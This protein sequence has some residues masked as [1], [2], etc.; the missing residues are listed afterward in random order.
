MHADLLTEF[1]WIV[2]SRA[3][4]VQVEIRY[5]I[6]NTDAALCMSIDMPTVAAATITSTDRVVYRLP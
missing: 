2:T 3:T 5:V 1:E 6:I 4:D